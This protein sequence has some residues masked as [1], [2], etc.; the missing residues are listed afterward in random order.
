MVSLFPT[1]SPKYNASPSGPVSA[2][3]SATS[4]AIFLSQEVHWYLIFYTT[5]AWV[6]SL[7]PCQGEVMTAL[8][9]PD[10]SDESGPLVSGLRVILLDDVGHQAQ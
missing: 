1:T 7:I 10:R 9:K 2:P 3:R 6:A 5:T 4:P 8:I